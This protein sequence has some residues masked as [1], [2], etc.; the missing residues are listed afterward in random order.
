MV[1][2]QQIGGFQLFEHCDFISEQLGTIEIFTAFCLA[3]QRVPHK[4]VSFV[5]F[6]PQASLAVAGGDGEQVHCAE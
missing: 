4:G 6:Q 5:Y 2:D 1:T 3:I